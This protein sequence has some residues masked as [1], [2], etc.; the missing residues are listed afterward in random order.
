MRYFTRHRATS[1]FVTTRLSRRHR[2]AGHT[3]IEILLALGL[4]LVILAAAYAAL[5]QHWRYADAGQRQTQRMQVTRALF[6][7]MSL[8]LRSV[9]FHP[10]TLSARRTGEDEATRIEV[11]QH[12]E[13]YAGRST[14][15]VG[16]GHKLVLH[17]DAPSAERSIGIQAIRWEMHALDSQDRNGNDAARRRADTV[18]RA[19]NETLGLARIAQP[20][21]A[22]DG[23][24]TVSPTDLSAAE[25]ETIRFRYFAHVSWFHDWDSV[26][27]QELPQAV[28]IT[29]G[30]RNV[31]PAAPATSGQAQPGEYHLLVPVPAS[32]A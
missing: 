16:D 2:G 20:E 18:G 10:A 11:V 24:T 30:L 13:Q 22:L 7:R 12:G 23:A 4:S 29:I 27:R 9:V 21:A 17:V 28:E 26:A 15:I 25:V 5:D 19:G 14:G 32:E 6:E 1:S 3:L 31:S 8:D